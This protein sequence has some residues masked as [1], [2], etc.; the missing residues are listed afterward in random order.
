M[1]DGSYLDNRTETRHNNIFN[2]SKAI[3]IKM[4]RFQNNK[5]QDLI[6]GDIPNNFN[7]AGIF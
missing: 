6:L 1:E 5:I 4:L 3:E 2:S 7:Q